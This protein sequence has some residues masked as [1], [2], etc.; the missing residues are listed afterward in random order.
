MS[1]ESVMLSN[2]LIL[3]CPLFLL[4]SI[5]ASNGF[6][7]SE[8]ALHIWWPRYWNFSFS[9]SPSSEY[10]GLI[11]FR[12]DWF[13]HLA[14]QGTLNEVVSEAEV[15]IFLEFSFFYSPTDVGS[16][17][18]GSSTFSKSSLY[19]WKFSVHVLLKSSLNDFEDYLVGI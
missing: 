1:V 15:G 3:F 12:M 19:I 9:I 6:F 7:S 18:S 4:P 11:S 14:V 17:I 5:F 2:H 8:L 10:S 16:L 13:D